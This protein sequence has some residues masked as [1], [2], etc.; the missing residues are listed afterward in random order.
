[1]LYNRLSSGILKQKSQQ[2]PW[3]QRAEALPFQR[4]FKAN[5]LIFTPAQDAAGVGRSA[6]HCA[7][8][9]LDLCS[10]TTAQEIWGN[11]EDSMNQHSKESAQL[12]N[13]LTLPRGFCSFPLL[14][15][16][17][18]A[19]PQT[20]NQTWSRKIIHRGR[21]KP[22]MLLAV[23]WVWRRPWEFERF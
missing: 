22:G 17:Q 9:R 2:V 19:K 10:K 4:E 1:M 8:E 7:S 14:G 23:V 21:E 16:I 20:E 15:D 11:N 3:T 6:L 13:E 5:C 18:F 12:G